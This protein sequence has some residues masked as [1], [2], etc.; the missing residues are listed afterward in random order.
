MKKSGDCSENLE[1][2]AKIKNYSNI[3]V[4]ISP[5]Y[6]ILAVMQRYFTR[7]PMPDRPKVQVATCIIIRLWLP[8]VSLR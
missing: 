1:I 3:H 2:F 8:V 6:L 4:A 7:F 5:V